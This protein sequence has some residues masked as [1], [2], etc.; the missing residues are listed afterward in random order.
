MHRTGPKVV[1]TMR[2]YNLAT[3]YI[4]TLGVTLVE[5]ADGMSFSSL[6]NELI[7]AVF[8]DAT[9]QSI[10]AVSQSVAP[11]GDVVVTTL[12]SIDY[13]VWV[14]FFLWPS[15]LGTL[16]WPLLMLDWAR[17]FQMA[18]LTSRIH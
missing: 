18:K 7:V 9:V 5:I 14:R 15:L 3:L 11:G 12:E 10:D 8:H 6:I 4:L 1:T 2:S 13:I 17:W 16:V